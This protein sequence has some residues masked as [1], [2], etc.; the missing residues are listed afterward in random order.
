MRETL[1]GQGDGHQ[2]GPQG[3]PAPQTVAAPG[4]PPQ[5]LHVR[6]DGGTSMSPVLGTPRLGQRG[7]GCSGAQPV[8]PAA[9]SPREA[10]PAQSF[11]QRHS[12]H[13][14]GPGPPHSPSSGLTFTHAHTR[15]PAP[16]GCG[17]ALEIPTA[18][19]HPWADGGEGTRWPRPHNVVAMSPARQRPLG[20]PKGGRIPPCHRPSFPIAGDWVAA[21]GLM[22]G[23]ILPARWPGP[24]WG[25]AGSGSGPGR[26]GPHGAGGFPSSVPGGSPT[27]IRAAMLLVT[28]RTWP[29]PRCPSWVLVAK[30]EPCGWGAALGIPFGAPQNRQR[31]LHG[32]ASSTGALSPA[33]HP[34]VRAGASSAP[35]VLRLQ[36]GSGCGSWGPIALSTAWPSP[37]VPPR[38]DARPSAGLQLWPRAQRGRG[39]VVRGPLLPPPLLRGLHRGQP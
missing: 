8:P 23:L 34:G 24:C 26:A 22:L 30:T 39:E 19:P 4:C 3:E 10:S 35:W 7:W 2:G 28:P 29:Q 36:E 18:M 25:C 38:P 5:P 33:L 16:A 15:T 11:V 1:G 31:P 9:R 20:Y 27:G 37:P 13:R 21:D 12:R 32:G 6:R 17:A 14:K